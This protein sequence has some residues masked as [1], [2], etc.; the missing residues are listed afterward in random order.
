MTYAEFVVAID[1]AHNRDEAAVAYFY[2]LQLW[3]HFDEQLWRDANSAILA[4]WSKASLQA[5]KRKA[6]RY[7]P[8]G[9]SAMA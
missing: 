7:A 5:I 8:E 2:A 3:D 1:K 6:W 4:R 9:S